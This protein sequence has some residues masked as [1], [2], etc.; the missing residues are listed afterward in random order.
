MTS[1]CFQRWFFLFFLECLQLKT[2][3]LPV[4]LLHQFI[5][6]AAVWAAGTTGAAAVW[7]T[8]ESRTV[9]SNDDEWG[10]ASQ[11]RR[12]SHGPNGRADGYE[13]N[14]DGTYAYGA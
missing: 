3:F 11:W 7:A 13:P 14:G 10:D 6:S 9:R 1:V 2:V 12:R 8:G 4:A 5:P